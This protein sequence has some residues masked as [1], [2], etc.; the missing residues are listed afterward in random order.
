VVEIDEYNIN[1][2]N[3]PILIRVSYEAKDK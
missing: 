2:P 1:F 3:I